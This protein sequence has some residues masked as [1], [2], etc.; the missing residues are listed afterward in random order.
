MSDRLWFVI[1]AVALPEAREA[2]EYG[3]METGA[4][5]TETNES[6][7]TVCVTGYS[8]DQRIFRGV[9]GQGTYS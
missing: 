6:D 1:D 8:E 3:L 7:V 5:G 2:I 4:L 9:A